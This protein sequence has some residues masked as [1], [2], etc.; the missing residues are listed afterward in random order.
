MGIIG[1]AFILSSDLSGAIY[2]DFVFRHHSETSD[3][4]NKYI[5][6]R[7]NSIVAQQCLFQTTDHN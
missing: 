5:C 2:V 7:V 4:N 1:T 3:E 6:D